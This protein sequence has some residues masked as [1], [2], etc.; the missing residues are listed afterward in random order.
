MNPAIRRL[1]GTPVHIPMNDQVQKSKMEE[2]KIILLCLGI[3]EI[4][5]GIAS[6]VLGI[7]ILAVPI[8][9]ISRPNYT[10]IGQGIWCGAI[11]IMSGINGLC[12]C[13]RTTKP[14]YRQNLILSIFAV[15]AMVVLLCLSG[16]AAVIGWPVITLLHLILVGIAILGIIIT[17]IHAAYSDI[18]V[19]VIYDEI[20]AMC[21]E[22]LHQQLIPVQMP[23]GLI[24]YL[25]TQSLQSSNWDPSNFQTK[26]NPTAFV[27]PN[28][29]IHPGDFLHRTTSLHGHNQ[30]H[31]P[32]TTYQYRTHLPTT[33]PLPT[34]PTTSQDGRE[35]HPSPTFRMPVAFVSRHM[36]P[37]SSGGVANIIR[38]R[39]STPPALT[40]ISTS[41]QHE[42]YLD[43]PS[44][45]QMANLNNSP[46]GSDASRVT[47]SCPLKGSE[48]F[49]L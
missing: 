47:E 21:S 24:L 18:T 27:S 5:L 49:Q 45:S 25:P 7:K 20:C 46:Q 16:I 34:R 17:S 31:S 40:P 35:P 22:A 4:V 10:N 19:P 1:Q 48:T 11:L 42:T 37:S 6:V 36:H 26:V 43:Q 8:V 28:Q 32:I 44:S 29:P 9:M 15:V 41:I 12:I 39:G 2:N 13:C 30:T 33:V 3:I 38:Q 14:V 23:D